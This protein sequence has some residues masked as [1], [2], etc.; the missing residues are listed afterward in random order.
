MIIKALLTRIPG[1]SDLTLVRSSAVEQLM[2]G[3]CQALEFLRLHIPISAEPADQRVL[4]SVMSRLAAVPQSSLRIIS[5]HHYFAPYGMLE[6]FGTWNLLFTATL[7]ARLL[8][9]DWSA[10]ATMVSLMPQLQTLSVY[11]AHGE[12]LTLSNGQDDYVTWNNGHY[13][14]IRNALA[15]RL[16]REGWRGGLD[17]SRQEEPWEIV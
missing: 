16:C 12:V 7:T 5:I 2:F 8:S 13:N 1:S 14:D 17:I 3:S 6:G 9:L 10:F 15:E 4:M 11:I